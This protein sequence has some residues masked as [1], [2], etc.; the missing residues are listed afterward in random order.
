MRA[1]RARQMPRRVQFKRD[2]E[3]RVLV[4]A[5]SGGLPLVGHGEPNVNRVTFCG[6]FV[7]V[8]TATARFLPTRPRVSGV[9]HSTAPP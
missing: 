7:Q 4:V 9:D 2:E 6:K 3:E 1:L 5:A 8:S